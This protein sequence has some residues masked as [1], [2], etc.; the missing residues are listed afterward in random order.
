MAVDLGKPFQGAL[1][2]ASD[3]RV[4]SKMTTW[5]DAA[6]LSTLAPLYPC[7]RIVPTT[8]GFGFTK[9][10]GMRRNADNNAWILDGMGKHLH[11]KDTDVDGGLLVDIELVNFGITLR[12][13]HT[14]YVAKDFYVEKSGTNADATDDISTGTG[15]AGRIKIEAGTTLN[16]YAN[17]RR[18]G[19]NLDFAQKSAFEARLEH[20]GATTNYLW[21]SGV[22]GEMINDANDPTNPSYG[23]E[24][25]SASGT[26]IL[27]WS[28]DSTTRSTLSSGYA[29]DTTNHTWILQHDPNTPNLVL[30]RDADFANSVPKVSNIPVSGISKTSCNH[31]SG[32]KTTDTVTKI[33]RWHGYV[34]IGRVGNATWKWLNP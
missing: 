1:A 24:A 15:T 32:M 4:N 9:D 3:A 8:T 34:I 18:P 22:S 29:V 11:S 20:N 21:R 27:I 6:Y 7:M 25:C 2:E 30:T 12:N 31:T 33:L 5:A 10:I 16:G 28:C 26:S 17:I 23:I 13:L 14:D 19:L